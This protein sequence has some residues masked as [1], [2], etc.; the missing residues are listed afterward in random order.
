[1]KNYRFW[2]GIFLLL[3]STFIFWQSFSLEYSGPYGP[4]PGLFPRWLSGI[5]II[6]SI[7]YIGSSIGKSGMSFKD[8]FPPKKVFFRILTIIG[9][10]LLFIIIAPYVGFNIACIL[11]L[12]ILLA[13]EYKWYS[14]FGISALVTI[15]LFVCFD[16]ILNV[17]LP[18]NIWGF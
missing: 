7:I 6:L 3:F 4:G 15:V 13:A 5:L 8:L 2:F 9:S 14:A 17:P 10:I 11:S 1:M 18:V 12:F 16:G